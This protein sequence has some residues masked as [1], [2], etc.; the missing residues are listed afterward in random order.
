MV[1]HCGCAP[2]YNWFLCERFVFIDVNASS[3]SGYYKYFALSEEKDDRGM[4]L[5]Q[6]YY[7]PQQKVEFP[8]EDLLEKEYEIQ[9][10]N[11][12]E[13]IPKAQSQFKVE[14]AFRIKPK[15]KIKGM[16]ED[17][18]IGTNDQKVYFNWLQILHRYIEELKKKVE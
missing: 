11:Y 16:A 17:I 13:P 3:E 5:K 9:N 8:T 18:R 14:Y 2:K 1:E 7:E 6:Y 4:V 12:V 10:Y 15:E